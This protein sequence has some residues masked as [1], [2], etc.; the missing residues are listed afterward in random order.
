[1]KGPLEAPIMTGRAHSTVEDNIVDKMDIRNVTAEMYW[2]LIS[3]RLQFPNI[4]LDLL[5]AGTDTGN[6][7]LS[8]DMTK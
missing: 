4:K 3:G 7:T 8:F 1:M 5:A 2:D 6:G